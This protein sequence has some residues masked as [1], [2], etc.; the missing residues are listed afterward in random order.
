L[1][2]NFIDGT[3]ISSFF[4]LHFEYVVH[5][6]DLLVG[7]SQIIFASVAVWHCNRW[8]YWWWGN[9]QVFDDHP[10]RSALMLIE[11]HQ[12]KI[13]VSYFSEDLVRLISKQDLLSILRLVEIFIQI[14]D[15]DSQALLA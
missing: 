6:N 9:G 11:S 5:L 14:L 10:F 12:L 7:I 1:S 4:N 8:S 3:L 13:V 2:Q 15:L